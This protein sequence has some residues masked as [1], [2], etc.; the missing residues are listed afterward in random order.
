M[1][2]ASGTAEDFVFPQIFIIS[3]SD[4]RHRRRALVDHLGSLGLQAQIQEAIDGR[5][6]IPEIYEPMLARSLANEKAG[7]PL[8]DMEF[9]CALSHISIY[10]TMITEEIQDA[11]VLEDDA[12]LLPG[13]DMIV[14]SP[15]PHWADLILFDHKNCFVR[16]IGGRR[17]LQKISAHQIAYRTPTLATG[18]R[19]SN[20]AAR[21][22][23]E[24]SLPVHE[25]IDWPEYI[26]TLRTFALAPRIVDHSDPKTGHSYLREVE[27]RA[28]L[29][30]YIRNHELLG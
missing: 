12:V 23:V 10:R 29:P 15:M 22:I 27:I 21:E 17:K 16:R 30:R 6:N 5:G 11:V 1:V 13:F 7:R 20:S 25:V 19:I 9:A 28:D 3:L 14:R 8:T 24:R 18:Y 26:L 2:G 4:A